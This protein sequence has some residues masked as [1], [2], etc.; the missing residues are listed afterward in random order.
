MYKKPQ[1]PFIYGTAWKEQA[2]TELVELAVKSGFIGIDTANQDKHYK[3]PMVGE[4]IA[5]I[6]ST[7]ISRE[8]L[9]LQSKFTS[10]SGQGATKPYDEKADIATQI[11]QSFESTLKNLHT[12]YLDSYLLHGPYN[13][14]LLGEEDFAA[15]E[16][17]ENLYGYRIVSFIGISNVN[18]EQIKM[19]VENAT[20]RPQIVQNRCYAN[21]LWD[22]DV[23]DFCKA[24]RIKYQGF[25][26]LTANMPLV[27]NPE[28]NHIA[29]K[30]SVT[31]EQII[32]RFAQQIGITPLTGTTNENHMIADLNILNLSLSNEEISSINKLSLHA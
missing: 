29:K 31:P 32:F 27:Q 21:T 24:N 6:T 13:H 30:H 25:S 16:A 14:P 8:Q 1:P 22:K 3:E 23:R 28:I 17:L 26:L 15:W 12:D 2:T 19:L 11:N 20:V 10:P 5:N 18:L 9:W 4:A 7:G